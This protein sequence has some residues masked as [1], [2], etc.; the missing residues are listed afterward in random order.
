MKNLLLS[1][2]MLLRFRTYTFINLTGLVFSVACALIIARYI[3]QENTVD[4]FCPELERTFLMTVINEEN[5]TRMAASKDVNNDHNF[6]DPLADPCVEKFCRFIIMDDDRVTANNRQFSVRSI[7]TDSLFLNFFPYPVVMGNSTIR[8]PSD[9]II[10]LSLAERLFGKE[11]PLGKTLKSSNGNMLTVTG[12]IDAPPTKASIQF[13]IVESMAQN[14][15]WRFQEQELV[16]LYRAEDVV[17]LNKKNETPMKLRAYMDRPVYYQLVPLQDFYF[18]T[19]VDTGRYTNFQRGN[20]KTLTILTIVAVLLLL[21]GTFN[22]INLHTVV[23]LKR[24]REFG[25]KKVYGAGG[26]QVFT[27]LYLENFCL[28]IIALLFIWLFIEITRGIVDHWL[29]IPVVTDIRFDLMVSAVLLFGM[30]L[31]TTLFPFIRYNYAPPA[32]SLRSISMGGHS[33]V[34]RMAFLLVQYTIT[35][36]LMVTA[37]YFCCQLYSMLNHDLG[38]K[39]KDIIEC[40]LYQRPNTF[41]IKSDEEQM[42]QRQKQ[43]EDLALTQRKMDESPLFTKWCYGKAPVDLKPWSLFTNPVNDKSEEV[44]TLFVNQS[45]MELF[46]F[47]LKDGRLWKDGEDQFEQYKLIINEAAQKYFDLND[48]KS[49]TLQPKQRL[50]WNMDTRDSNPAYE[51]VGIVK[52][53]KTG[54]LSRPDYPLA[55]IYSENRRGE[56]LLASIAPGKRKEAIAYLEKLFHEINGEGD[57][58]YS[59][60]E[61]SITDLYKEDKRTAYIYVT[62]ALIAILISCLGLFGLS[63]YD[64]RQRYREIALRKVNG[65]AARDIYRLLL[66]KY[67]YIMSIAFVIGSSVSFVFIGKYMEDFNYR[68]PLSPWIFIAAG[69]ITALISLCTLWS[70]INR[71]VKLDPAKIMKN[72]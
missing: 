30:P 12:V 16:Q 40:T 52:D 35:I 9:A 17:G 47:Q 5:H 28:G 60:I 27:Q 7:I 14:D 38:Y 26:R 44:I 37:I 3:H 61:D 55:F 50:W 48:L 59:F 32:S 39:T 49:A 71:A 68:A 29:G 45:Y 22:Y 62:F 67:L 31:L 20:Q 33:T 25:V 41:D 24:A 65:A 53:F 58:N 1:I 21:V 69:G 42:A 19:K 64:I 56:I 51:I 13:D 23:M 72:E 15:S 43:K 54:H 57:F 66:H 8:T 2:R 70:Q 63:L 34:S 6:K 11:V 36:C 18:E 10:T 4:H 46:E